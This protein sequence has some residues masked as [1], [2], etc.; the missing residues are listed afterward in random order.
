MSQLN[1]GA[2]R[3]EGQ[4]IRTIKTSNYVVTEKKEKQYV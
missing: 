2:K 3:K 1:D 4:A